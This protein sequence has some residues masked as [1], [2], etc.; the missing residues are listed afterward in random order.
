MR[1]ATLQSREDQAMGLV[2]F[3]TDF[4]R[5]HMVGVDSNGLKLPRKLRQ[6]LFPFRS[7][8]RVSGVLLSPTI[9]AVLSRTTAVRL[10]RSC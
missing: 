9:S 6:S 10:M 8:L 5:V 4:P 1:E 2:Y 3:F 7:T